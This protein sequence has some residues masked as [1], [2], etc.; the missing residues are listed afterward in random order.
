MLCVNCD[1]PTT[2]SSKYCT[3]HRAE[4][5]AAWK[6]RI[7]IDQVERAARE[8]RHQEIITEA[9]HAAQLAYDNCEPAAMLVYETV[10]L[11]DMPK[12]NGKA[13][14]V[15]E[16]VCGFAWLV[17]TPATS[18]FARWLAKKDIG[19]KHYKGGWTI[20]ANDLVPN[21]NQSYERKL[22]AMTA[23]AAVLRTHDIACYV[24]SR[25]D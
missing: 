24:D 13:W 16:G 9:A 15:A 10:G 7:E 14:I 11:S 12:E 18:S 2:G 8:L 5:R 17:V 21:A 3:T 22:A 23:A 4:A 25:L 1:Q 6:A 19:Y 20:H